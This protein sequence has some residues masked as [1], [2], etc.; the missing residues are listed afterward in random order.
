MRILKQAEG[1]NLLWGKYWK[2]PSQ[3]LPPQIP[4]SFQHRHT[5]TDSLQCKALYLVLHPQIWH[6]EKTTYLLLPQNTSSLAYLIPEQ[7]FLTFLKL[8]RLEGKVQYH[9]P[10][11]SHFLCAFILS[12]Y[13]L[14]LS[15][16]VKRF[17][18]FK[19]KNKSK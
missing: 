14:S 6:R 7:D 3:G 4:V 11:T 18:C 17:A 16:W 15:P 5:S 12:D 8:D 13:I 19:I 9:R 2:V 10:V 1:Q